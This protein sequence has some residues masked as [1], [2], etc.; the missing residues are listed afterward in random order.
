MADRYWF[1][2]QQP[3]YVYGFYGQPASGGPPAAGHQHGNP[4]QQNEAPFQQLAP[5]Q[6]FY[7]QQAF[8]A[9]FSY[10]QYGAAAAPYGH[11]AG[12]M[13][14]NGC[15]AAYMAAPHD[16]QQQQQ[17][18]QQHQQ[19]QQQQ[20]PFAVCTAVMRSCTAAMFFGSSALLTP[21]SPPLRLWVTVLR[22]AGHFNS[23]SQG[24]VTCV[25]L[26]VRNSISKQRVPQLCTSNTIGRSA[27]CSWGCADGIPLVAERA[28]AP[29]AGAAVSRCHD[30]SRFPASAAAVAS[31]PRAQDRKAALG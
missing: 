16:M 11:P 22:S 3:A 25:N 14:H 21:R 1:D 6:P 2:Q 15:G 10:D 4:H 19:H 17:Q 7:G 5:G 29:D 28:P 18:H 26:I 9:A 23:I 12:F 13:G 30:P 24:I 8:D 20:D 27:A 31:Q